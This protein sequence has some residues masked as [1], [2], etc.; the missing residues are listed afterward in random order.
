MS[1]LGLK[2]LHYSRRISVANKVKQKSS[3]NSSPKR[4]NF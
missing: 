1:S 3:Q 2:F 4:L